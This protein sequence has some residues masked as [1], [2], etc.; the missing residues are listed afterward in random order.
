MRRWVGFW[1]WRSSIW[2]CLFDWLVELLDLAHGCEVPDSAAVPRPS[3]SSLMP[4]RTA[5]HHPDRPRRW[6]TT[7]S[8]P[9]RV[10]A[11][12]RGVD[13]AVR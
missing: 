2:H 1:P 4:L 5:P 6:R 8:A 3:A 7:R 10:G 13:D 9:T 12:G 11:L